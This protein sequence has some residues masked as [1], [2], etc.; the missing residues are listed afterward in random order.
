MHNL[1]DVWPTWWTLICSYILV[2]VHVNQWLIVDLVM[3]LCNLLQSMH[4][5]HK[6]STINLWVLN[7][8]PN[9]S[10]WFDLDKEKLTTILYLSLCFLSTHL[11]LR[12]F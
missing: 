5:E 8:L 7:L 11:Y 6:R 3:C 9:L 2:N 1:I 12:P 4:Y 10:T